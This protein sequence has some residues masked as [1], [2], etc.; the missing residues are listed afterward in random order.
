M[1]NLKTEVAVSGTVPEKKRQSTQEVKI[2]PLLVRTGQNSVRIFGT[3]ILSAF[4]CFY[5]GHQTV[6]FG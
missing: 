3:I 6:S 2:G 5:K 1:K 4:F